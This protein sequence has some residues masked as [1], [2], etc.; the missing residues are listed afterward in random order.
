MQAINYLYCVTNTSNGMIYVGVHST[1]KLDDGYLGSGKILKQA[2]LKYG[3]GCFKKDIIK[4]FDTRE[5]MFCAEKEIV[6]EIFVNSDL[7][8]NLHI[9]GRGER[10]VRK[11]QFHSELTKLKMSISSK[12][13]RN[14]FFGKT[15]SAQTKLKIAKASSLRERTEQ[16]R[17]KMSLKH[18]GANNPMFGTTA[19][20]AKEIFFEGVKYPSI[21][22]AAK[23]SGLNIN[24]FRRTYL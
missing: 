7:T 1:K 6:N 19:P 3:K 9:G 17:T 11:G 13:N 4:F 10:I 18:S 5:E 14:G 15:H 12:A 16:H 24:K 22:A 20:N 21:T 8:Y 23:A 2:L